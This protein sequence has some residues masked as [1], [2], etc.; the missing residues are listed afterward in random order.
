[1]KDV[2]NAMRAGLGFRW[3][4][5][6]LYRLFHLGAGSSG[7]QEFRLRQADEFSIDGTLWATCRLNRTGSSAVGGS[8]DGSMSRSAPSQSAE[9]IA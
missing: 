5:M 9:R 1:M 7:L 2:D 6:S 3:T 4:A 8:V